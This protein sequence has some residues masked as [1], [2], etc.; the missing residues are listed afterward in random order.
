[1]VQATKHVVKKC[2]GTVSM[3]GECHAPFVQD[4]DATHQLVCSTYFR[5]FV[6]GTKV[7][8]FGIPVYVIIVFQRFCV[9]CKQNTA[10]VDHPTPSCIL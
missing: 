4:L 9:F 1:M 6:V 7:C 8:P 3:T 10:V 2:V 5:L